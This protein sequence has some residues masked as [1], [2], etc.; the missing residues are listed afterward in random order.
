MTICNRKNTEKNKT[1]NIEYFFILEYDQNI[2]SHLPTVLLH[3]EGMFHI[4]RV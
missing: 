4:G 1:K 3:S 2:G